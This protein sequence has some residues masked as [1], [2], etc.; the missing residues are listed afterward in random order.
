MDTKINNYNYTHVCIC[1][2][3]VGIQYV[4]GVCCVHV[5]VCACACYCAFEHCSRAKSSLKLCSAIEIMLGGNV[6]FK[7]IYLL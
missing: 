1:C 7:L 6:K 4:H 5:C 2:Q 3:V